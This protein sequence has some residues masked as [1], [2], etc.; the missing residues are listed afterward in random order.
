[1]VLQTRLT[2]HRKHVVRSSAGHNVASQND[3]GSQLFHHVGMAGI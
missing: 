2:A 3:G 1:M